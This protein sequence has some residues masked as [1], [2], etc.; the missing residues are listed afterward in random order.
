MTLSACDTVR[1]FTAIDLPEEVRGALIALC[2]GIPGV[3]W[4]RPE[5]LHLTLRFIGAVDQERFA[6]IRERLSALDAPPL[7]V[8]L[9][10]VGTF[11][12]SGPPRVLWAGIE[13]SGALVSLRDRIE[14]L[15]VAAGC[16]PETRSFFPHV[17]LARLRDIPRSMVGTYLARHASFSAGP[18]GVEQFLLYSSALFRQGS[19]HTVE[20]RYPLTSGAAPDVPEHFPC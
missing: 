7:P 5:Q 15:L 1:L 13:Q 2:H 3:R 11:P 8:T 16:E 10:R 14:E 4:V 17:T 20:Q 12:R 19:I 9:N 6:A 18:F